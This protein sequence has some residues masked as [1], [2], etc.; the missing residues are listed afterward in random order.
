M[1]NSKYFLFVLI[2]F[3][4]FC[5]FVLFKATKQISN[6]EKAYVREIQVTSQG[7]VILSCE[8]KIGETTE[9]SIWVLKQSEI[10]SKIYTGNVKFK[11]D[12]RGYT[13]V[14]NN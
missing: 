14:N 9:K 11:K 5:V 1:K 6:W 12:G 2:I 7:F 10:N 4:S 8:E 3:I 13:F